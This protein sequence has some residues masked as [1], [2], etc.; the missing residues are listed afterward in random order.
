MGLY[1]VW[2]EVFYGQYFKFQ[3]LQ[4]KKIYVEKQLG[5]ELGNEKVIA[6]L[7]QKFVVEE[8]YVH[9]SKV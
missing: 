9:F 6:K 7:E 1:H 2:K 4:L 8:F 3:P 5:E